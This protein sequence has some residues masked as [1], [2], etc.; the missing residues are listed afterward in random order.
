MTARTAGTAQGKHLQMFH[1]FIFLQ[2]LHLKCLKVK[3]PP[4]VVVVKS[5]PAQSPASHKLRTPFPRILPGSHL[6]SV[7]DHHHLE[8]N[9]SHLS[10]LIKL[11]ISLHSPRCHIVST[12]SLLCNPYL[13]LPTSSILHRSVPSVPKS[14]TAPLL[15][16]IMCMYLTLTYLLAAPAFCSPFSSAP[17][18]HRLHAPHVPL[19]SPGKG[20]GPII[21]QIRTKNPRHSPYLD[22]LSCFHPPACVQ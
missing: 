19:E 15:L 2:C 7:H 21:S 3:Q 10:P 13:L 14:S 17:V 12:H 20:K 18:L 22:S 4:L 6:L 9:S 1:L 11:S 8:S 16:R 5:S